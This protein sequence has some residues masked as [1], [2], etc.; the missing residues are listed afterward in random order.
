MPSASSVASTIGFNPPDATAS[1]KRPDTLFMN[2]TTGAT[3]CTRGMS[4]PK[5]ASLC[6]AVSSDRHPQP[7]LCVKKL[8]H[9]RRRHPADRIKE[10]LREVAPSGSHRRQPRLVVQRHRVGQR[11]VAIEDV[12]PEIH[13]AECPMSSGA[14]PTSETIRR[15]PIFCV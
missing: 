3:G 5:S 9:A 1:G 8:D 10:F 7:K 13:L 12:R 6:S 2:S 14:H 11:A 4:L 15:L